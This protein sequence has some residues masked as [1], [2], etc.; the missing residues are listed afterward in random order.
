MNQQQPTKNNKSA[1]NRTFIKAGSLSA[2]AS[3]KR[4]MLT[5]NETIQAI[6]SEKENLLKLI[7][8]ERPPVAPLAP[9]SRVIEQSVAEH[10]VVEEQNAVDDQLVRDQVKATDSATPTTAEHSE[11]HEGPSTIKRRGKTQMHKVHGRNEKQLITLNQN[12]QPVGPTDEAV[13]ELSSFL[14]ILA[15]KATLCPFD[16]FDWRQMDTKQNLWDY[17]KAKYEIPDVAKPWVLERIRESW[18]I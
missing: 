1:R 16:I 5:T 17:T 12:N 13:S 6:Q 2:M 18:R 14:G 11:A 7:E 3:R 10:H 9:P 8:Q 15:R 4:R